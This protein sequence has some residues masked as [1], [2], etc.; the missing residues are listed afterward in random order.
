MV[1]TSS[2]CL[3]EIGRKSKL[4]RE[5]LFH[6]RSNSCAGSEIGVSRA[7]F[8]WK[9]AAPGTAS[10]LDAAPTKILIVLPFV[11]R[12]LKKASQTMLAPFVLVHLAEGIYFI[13]VPEP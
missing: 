5:D 13:C 9:A 12:F 6:R 2:R 7:A 1:R 11:H 4:A 3:G 10:D 8:R